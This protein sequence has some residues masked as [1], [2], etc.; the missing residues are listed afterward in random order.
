MIVCDMWLAGTDILCLDMLYL[1]KAMRDHSLIQAVSRVN[2]VFLDKPHGLIV[3][4]IGLGDQLRDA[5]AKFAQAGDK[6]EPAPDIS[7]TAR[8]LFLGCRDE[9]HGLLPEGRDYGTR[10]GLPEIELEDLYALVYGRL[11]DDDSLRNQFLQA[12]MRLSSAFGW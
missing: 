5:T 4:Y 1:D 12:E 9:V 7:S 10:R 3:D 11:A 8:P 2:R 6:A